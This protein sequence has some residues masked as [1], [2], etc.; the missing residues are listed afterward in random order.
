MVSKEPKQTNKTPQRIIICPSN[1]SLRYVPQTIETRDP[2]RN[3]YLEAVF[4]T[5]P[6][7]KQ[8]KCPRTGGW[9]TKM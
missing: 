4:T 6:N 5:F 2:N 9:F 3:S 8:S 1:S 7:W